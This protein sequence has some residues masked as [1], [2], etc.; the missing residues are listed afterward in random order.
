MTCQ[1]SGPGKD[2]RKIPSYPEPKK[3]R[4]LK[5]VVVALKMPRRWSM[6]SIFHFVSK[7][8]NTI[9]KWRG[10]A[11][12]RGGIK[13][14]LRQDDRTGFLYLFFLKKKGSQKDTDPITKKKD[15]EAETV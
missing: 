2:T 8:K 5:S 6:A 9:G 11:K 1:T 12:S 13:C 10:K 14:G 15:N 3:K 7:T 4:N